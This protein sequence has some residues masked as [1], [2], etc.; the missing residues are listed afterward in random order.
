MREEFSAADGKEK[1]VSSRTRQ[2]DWSNELLRSFSEKQA[3]ALIA[4]FV[5]NG[6]WQT[7][8]LILLQEDSYR[9][10]NLS[11]TPDQRVKYVPRTVFDRWKKVAQQ[12]A[13][14]AQA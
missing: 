3:H 8:T 11:D 10:G 2:F 7:P 4:E 14:A 12:D 9:R 1:D 6:T 13:L 5:A